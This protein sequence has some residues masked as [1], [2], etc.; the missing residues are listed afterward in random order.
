MILILNQFAAIGCLILWWHKAR[1]KIHKIKKEATKKH[2]LTGNDM[3]SIGFNQY[4]SD[5]QMKTQSNIR[6]SRCME[7][8]IYKIL[9]QYTTYK[10]LHLH[11][12]KVYNINHNGIYVW[13]YLYI[14][15]FT[16]I[17][18]THLFLFA[19]YIFT[20]LFW[21]IEMSKGKSKFFIK[22]IHI[23]IHIHIL[24]L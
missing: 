18:H 6:L 8:N 3:K 20:Y 5:M 4:K 2:I 14:Y 1:K 15:S 7:W 16:I 24:T 13:M 23:Y 9:N 17:F 19:A 12:Y 21:N 10:Y 11:I 22:C